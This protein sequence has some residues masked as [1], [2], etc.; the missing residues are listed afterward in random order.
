M[1]HT[2]LIPALDLCN[3]RH[4]DIAH[5]LTSKMK[6]QQRKGH[7]IHVGTVAYCF[8]WSLGHSSELWKAL[9]ICFAACNANALRT[10][11]LLSETHLNLT[12]KYI[13]AQQTINSKTSL[14]HL[15]G[16]A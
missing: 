9:H 3:P 6:R 10:A 5:M 12:C 14:V 11:L 7:T 2:V 13:C 15:V 4:A 1:S 16:F 8:V